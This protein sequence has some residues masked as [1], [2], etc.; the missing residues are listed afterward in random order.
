MQ[1]CD[2]AE[3][4][5]SKVGNMP[6]NGVM[7]ACGRDENRPIT[8]KCSENHLRKFAQIFKM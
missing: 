8:V 4:R 5:D 7:D 1:V 6:K 3:R 2:Y